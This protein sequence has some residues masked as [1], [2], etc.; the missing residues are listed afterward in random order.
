[1]VVALA[2]P[3]ARWTVG[4]EQEGAVEV[5]AHD[6]GQ[7]AQERLQVFGQGFDLLG[8]RV[9]TPTSDFTGTSGQLVGVQGV[10][11]GVDAYEPR[12]AGLDRS[13]DDS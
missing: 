7:A 13:S 10:G 8:L 3:R 2:C 4:I 6:E 11:V 9:V 5:A 1:V 12:P